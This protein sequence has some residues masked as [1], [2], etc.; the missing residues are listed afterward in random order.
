M[1]NGPG[2]LRV[3]KDAHIHTS[4][5]LLGGGLLLTALVTWETVSSYSTSVRLLLSSPAL[6]LDYSA[7]NWPRILISAGYTGSEAFLGLMLATLIG[8][9]FGALFLYVPNAARIVY[10]WLL[11]SQ[12]VP[13]VCLAP[14]IILVFGIGMPGKIFLSALMAFFPILTNLVSGVKSVPTSSLELMRIMAAKHATVLRH[15]VIPHCLYYFFTGLRVAAPFSVI[16]AVVAE[17][18]GADF[19]IGKDVYIAAKRLEPE[20]MMIGI[21]SGA[22]LSGLIYTLI[23]L[24]EKGLG[25][26]YRES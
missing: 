21:I 14:L 17:F 4:S 18:N 23:I 12:I 22:T 7:H 24:V 8:V 1:G 26:W 10:P 20:M 11:T 9:G 25:D 5:R 6:L 2:I 15:V 3:L 19:G 13:F 16:G